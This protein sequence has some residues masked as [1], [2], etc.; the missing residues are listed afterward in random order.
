V[1]ATF[2][3]GV[4]R[5]VEVIGERGRVRSGFE[6]GGGEESCTAAGGGGLTGEV[7]D[8]PR[9]GVGFPGS[10]TGIA[11]AAVRVRAA[12]PPAP[13][14]WAHHCAV[15]W[16]AAWVSSRGHDLL[17]ARE[18]LDGDEWSGEI[19][20]RDYHG[21]KSA[22]HRPD[23]V[24]CRRGGDQ[25]AIEVELTKKSAERLPAILLRHAVWRSRG[26]TGGVGYVVAEQD[27]CERIKNYAAY[28]GG[29]GIADYASSCS[30][31]A[32]PRRSPGLRTDGRAAPASPQPQTA[33][34]AIDLLKAKVA[35]LQGSKMA[36]G[37]ILQNIGAWVGAR[38]LES[39][40]PSR[41]VTL[42]C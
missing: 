37:P 22:R 7:S 27:G 40:D 33:K 5:G 34:F 13:T 3:A 21:F 4:D 42:K 11:V 19:S 18:L 26:Q 29:F 25:V 9:R 38:P 10:R 35:Y 8:D 2:W 14:W 39:V 24:A 31:R 12:G 15:A 28:V 1:G 20:W 6:S 16:T 32:R 41:A 30:I 36:L 17:G 23:L